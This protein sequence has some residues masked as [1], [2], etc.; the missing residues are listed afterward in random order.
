MWVFYYREEDKEK[1]KHKY[2]IFEMGGAEVAEMMICP[3]FQNG[4]NISQIAQVVVVVVALG[5]FHFLFFEWLLLLLFSWVF[6][7]FIQSGIYIDHSFIDRERGK[8]KE[9]NGGWWA[10]KAFNGWIETRETES[11][12]EG[13]WKKGE[14][15]KEGGQ[16]KRV[17]RR[18]RRWEN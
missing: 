16:K 12:E 11:V 14:E 2:E 6:I 15:G 1:S 9:R 3:R 13:G 5:H 10:R 7:S 4:N 17:S 18:G 8:Q